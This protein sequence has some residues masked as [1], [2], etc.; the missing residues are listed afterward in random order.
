[1]NKALFTIIFS[2]M[3]SIT[4][5]G[6]CRL[7]GNRAFFKK[8]V[9]EEE[10]H[11]IKEKFVEKEFKAN[12]M[13]IVFED[14]NDEVL[15]SVAAAFPEASS[16]TIQKCRN[17]TSL[18]AINSFN[19]LRSI[20]LYQ[21]N[22]YDKYD[23]KVLSRFKNLVKLEINEISF[24][25]K[26]MSFLSSMENLKQLV[27]TRL[28]A[29]LD[30]KGMEGLKNLE[31][32]YITYSEIGDL[33]PVSKCS[34]ITK[35]D[36]MY[37]SIDDMTLLNQLPK[38][39]VISLIGAQIKDFSQLEGVPELNELIFR[40]AKVEN[41]DFNTLGSLKQVKRFSAGMTNMDNLE[42]V[43]NT[44][45]IQHLALSS[46]HE[47]I[48][49]FTPLAKAYNLRSFQA[50]NMPTVG[51]LSFL[52]NLQFIES[53]YLPGSQYTNLN[54]LRSLPKLVNLDLSDAKNAVDLSFIK[55]CPSIKDLNLSNSRILYLDSLKGNKTIEILNIREVKNIESLE[56]FNS[57]PNLKLLNLNKSKY[58][59]E[60]LKVLDPRIR[61][62]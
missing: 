50:M 25:N 12:S 5:W 19:D 7:S 48:K 13:I 21:C 1:M 43:K 14:V 26:D 57:M 35:I 30:L 27:L 31:M 18:D 38:L 33:K 55:G 56:L 10:I 8:D 9:S 59:E 53:I 36:F 52:S 4:A 46:R 28:P 6:D 34:K 2:A 16:L 32:L 41:N 11:A 20:K 40:S 23:L 47:K 61:V 24:S 17:L 29:R 39:S 60:Q 62:I 22:H 51:D 49:D 44:P 37:S 45:Q 54:A 15:S 3:L 42:W 58:T